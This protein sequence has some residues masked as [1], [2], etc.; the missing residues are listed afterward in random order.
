MKH[1]TEALKSNSRALAIYQKRVQFKPRGQEWEGLCPFHAE[2][3]P[4]F[5]LFNK[6]NGWAFICQ[7]C[8]KGGDVIKFIEL[9]D[10]VPVK[11]AMDIVAKEVGEWGGE[12]T[13]T[14]KALEPQ[15]KDRITI[16]LE[17]WKP[18]EV[19][20]EQNPAARKWLETER[21]VG[22]ETAKR[23]GLGY[24]QE[25]KFVA[26]KHEHLK[27]KGWVLFP[28]I[29]G[30]KVVAIKYR[31][32]V[33]KAF[34]QK[35]DMDPSMLFNVETVNGLEPI[36][37][38][39]GELDACIFEQAGYNAVSVPSAGAKLTPEMKS[40]LKMA[41]CV[42]LAGDNDIASGVGN[43]YMKQLALELAE[44]AYVIT[45]E[46][47]KDANDVFRNTC[48]RDVAKFR[49]L[50]EQEK[51]KA[52]SNPIEG[53]HAIQQR[54]RSIQGVD[55]GE[56]ETRLHFPHK[57]VDDMN[58]NPSG[59]VVIITSTYS[60][61]GKSMFKTEI[62]LHEAAR[63]EVV[64]DFS[65]EIRGDQYLALVTSQLVGPS[66]QG[67]LPRS[68][69]ISREDFLEAADLLDEP[70][71]RG[72]EQ[73]YF[74]GH[75]LPVTNS[76]EVLQ[77]LEKTIQVTGCTR[78]AIDTFHRLVFTD[79]RTNQIEAEGK[80]IK[81]LEELAGKYGTIFIL[82][83][84]SNKEAEGIDSQKKDEHGVLRGSRE[85]LDVPS[86]IYLL[87]RKRNAQKDGQDPDKLLELE[88]GVFC[89]KD[90]YT[91]PGK[92]QTRL[93]LREDV[94]RFYEMTNASDGATFS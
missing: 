76:E 40:K 56:D 14:F 60:G 5:Q 28:R 57:S 55:M 79:G 54:L 15:V 41:D 26:P 86:G 10:K 36:F 46:G 85:M 62:L 48:G 20:L 8:K 91:G 94:S 4:S 59:S 38:T 61:T 51:V 21:A 93:F 65:P 87:H 35:K 74:V 23:L 80:L 77:F 50:V 27:N 11:D 18:Y 45:W 90:R 24:V 30:D 69:K 12:V 82:I 6:G 58:Y 70:S 73:R 44:K 81:K 42:Y 67:G 33:E 49:E 71:L 17:A 32:I 31:S 34:T 19:A 63:G 64:V 1:D 53:F 83:C 13:D 3:T 89:K 47:E 92:P 68:K 72:T 84:Q 66:R 16:P 37:V 43:V 2:K 22:Y 39:E 78:F 25:C 7:G 88:C 9:F 75:S 29:V 52:R